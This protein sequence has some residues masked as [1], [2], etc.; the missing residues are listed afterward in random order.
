MTA[1]DVACLWCVDM[2]HFFPDA[3]VENVK[4][5]N[6]LNQDWRNWRRKRNDLLKRGGKKLQLSYVWKSNDSLVGQ[7]GKTAG[8]S[9][10]VCDKREEGGIFERGNNLLSE[11]MSLQWG[12]DRKQETDGGKERK[13][14]T[15]SREKRNTE[16]GFGEKTESIRRET[17][18]EQD[19][20]WEGKW[21]D[22][23]PHD[24][25][26]SYP[27]A[28]SKPSIPS[29]RRWWMRKG[30]QNAGWSGIWIQRV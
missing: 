3:T 12:P 7:G 30:R 19:T 29:G 27:K 9:Y 24:L 15:E 14:D 25:S 20:I 6:G 11:W 1:F 5:S 8:I 22:K 21:R 10:T 26:D 17:S 2:F 23:L 28:K 4:W 13:G 18:Q 16:G